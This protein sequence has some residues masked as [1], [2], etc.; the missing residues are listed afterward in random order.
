MNS[1]GGSTDLPKLE[2][3]DCTHQAPSCICSIW[4]SLRV[5]LRSSK[6]MWQRLKN[7]VLDRPGRPFCGRACNRI[8]GLATNPPSDKSIE[9]CSATHRGPR[10][11]FVT[12][13][14]PQRHVTEE[15]GP[16]SRSG[17]G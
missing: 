9:D 16:R 10:Q 15:G 6:D 5:G 2:A 7:I 1:Q 3:C 12:E 13:G 4:D 8:E 17:A 11:G 14:P